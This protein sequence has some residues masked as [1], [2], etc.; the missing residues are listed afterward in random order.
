MSDCYPGVLT[1]SNQLRS[2]KYFDSIKEEGEAKNYGDLLQEIQQFK[3]NQ[4][5]ENI[6]KMSYQHPTKIINRGLLQGKSGGFLKNNL[7]QHHDYEA[8]S[9]EIWKYLSSWYT[10]DVVIERQIR[11][12]PDNENYYLD[13]HPENLYINLGNS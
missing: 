12:D 11:Y 10:Y 3:R 2:K 9:S 4:L 8:V 13:M 5:F 7:I 1:G 6:T